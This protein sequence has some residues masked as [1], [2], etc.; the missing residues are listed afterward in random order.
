MTEAMN[1]L[2]GVLDR[3]RRLLEYL[4]FKVIATQHLLE[5]GETRFLGWCSSEVEKA[6]QRVKEAEL[7]RGA[8]VARVSGELEVTSARPT[9][10]DLVGCSP[11]P[12]RAI[13]HDHHAALHGLMDE[14]TTVTAANRELASGGMRLVHDVVELIESGIDGGA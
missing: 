5:A 13:L 1:A 6:A 2:T 9:L 7:L 12:Y 4:L 3:E 11:E 10:R 8:I 14:I